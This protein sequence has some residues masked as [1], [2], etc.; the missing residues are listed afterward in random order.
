MKPCQGVVN[1]TLLHSINLM[2][3]ANRNCINY[4]MYCYVLT[5]TY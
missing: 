3:N 1:V 4:Y 5:Y 2:A